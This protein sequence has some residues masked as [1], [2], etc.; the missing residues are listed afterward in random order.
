[1]A[2]GAQAATQ[3]WRWS[4]YTLAICLTLLL[5]I[6]AFGFEETKYIPVESPST[7]AVDAEPVESNNDE[8][9]KNGEIKD[10][11]T[12]EQPLQLS[13]SHIVGDVSPPLNTYKERMR[14]YTPTSESLIRVFVAPAKV[15][16]FP[17][18]IFTALQFASG[19]CWLVLLLTMTTIVFSAPPYSFDTAGVGLMSLGPF[20][21]NCLGSLYGG[22]LSD[23]SI[24]RFAKRN[25]G[26]YEPEMRLYIMLPATLFMSGGLAMFGATAG[27]VSRCPSLLFLSTFS[28]KLTNLQQG[29]HWIY[30]SLGGAFFAAG[31]GAT[32]DIAFTFVIDAYRDVSLSRTCHAHESCA[33]LLVPT[34][35]NIYSS[36][37]SSSP[38]L[39]L[40]SP[41]S[42]TPSAS[43]SL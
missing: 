9:V 33:P 5:V 23:W 30:P 39:S 2:G 6:F 8:E 27:L 3:G 38:R 36:H 15:I 14:M 21:G 28:H 7:S 4:Y 25:G 40:V 42:A 1:M 17:H 20:V 22:P 37:F 34:E 26:V 41:L 18:V 29:M 24:K 13:K 19:V 10:D 35:A 32:G 43:P 31:L 16:F 11:K 12:K